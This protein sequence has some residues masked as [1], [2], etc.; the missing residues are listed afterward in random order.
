VAITAT[1]N[2]DR[3]DAYLSMGLAIVGSKIT[4]AMLFV[5]GVVLIG[6]GFYLHFAIPLVLAKLYL[7]DIGQQNMMRNILSGTIGSLFV[8]GIVALGVTDLIV[9]VGLIK[10]K[11]WAIKALVMLVIA[12]SCLNI[13][14]LA[15]MPNFTSLIFMIVGAIVDASILLYI[16]KKNI[17]LTPQ[18]LK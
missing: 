13:L 10:K 2:Y 8:G 1:F 14:T 4:G 3:A 5:I 12:A 9:A 6:V 17:H 7:F 15:G 16:W 18:K 11:Q